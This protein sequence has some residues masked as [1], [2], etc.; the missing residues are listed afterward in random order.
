MANDIDL[1][2]RSFL[3]RAAIV[4]AATRLG[5]SGAA[6]ATE[7]DA[8]EGG[9]PANYLGYSRIENF[10]SPGGPELG[11]RHRYFAPSRLALDQWALAGDWTIAS[12]LVRSMTREARIVN[13]F[14]ARDLHLVMG[15]ARRSSVVRFRVSL[16]GR[17]PG[18]AHGADVDDA[19]NGTVAELRLYR[20]IRQPTALADRQCEIEFIDAGIE[21]FAFRFS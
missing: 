18:S 14:H 9:S 5:L 1:G 17:P 16:D 20:L 21:A 7:H 8:R 2:R 4:I 11:R 19:G 10:A 3:G 13:R 6:Q 12:Q 15:P